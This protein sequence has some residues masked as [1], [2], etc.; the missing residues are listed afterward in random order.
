MV[1]IAQGKNT[2]LGRYERE[3]KSETTRISTMNGP[4][5]EGNANKGTEV[6]FKYSGAKLKK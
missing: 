2:F 6:N 1:K 4:K 5:K 3:Q